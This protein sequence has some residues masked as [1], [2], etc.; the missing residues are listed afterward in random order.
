MEDWLSHFQHVQGNMV[1]VLSGLIEAETPTDDKQAI[2][3]LG[4]WMATWAQGLGAK[5]EIHEQQRVGNVTICYWNSHLHEKP[6]LILCHLDTV[7][8][9]G[10][11][12]KRPTHSEGDILYGVGSYDMK[13]GITVAQ[14]V[15]E[16][17]HKLN[18]FPQR[19]I[20]LFL[21]TDEEK[22]SHFSRELI[23]TMGK[24][25]GLALVME[26]ALYEDSIVTERKG[27]GI[28]Q[29]VA[30]GR[31]A[32]SGSD[33]EKGVNAI[34]EMAYQIGRITA[35]SDK[36]LGTTA[37]PTMIQGGINHNVIPDECDITINV[38]AKY[39]TEA[40]RVTRD[41]LALGKETHFEDALVYVTGGFFRPPMEHNATM[42]TTVETLQRLLDFPVTEVSKGGGSDGNFTAALGIPTLDGLGPTGGGAHSDTEFVN[43]SSMA[44][45][46]AL[47]STILCDWPYL[48][49]K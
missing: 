28:F 45:R 49:E 48:G 1:W 15:I 30:M 37:I 4:L 11:V 19:P 18:K 7:H 41:L 46:A 8:P 47:L 24:Q 25:A 16:E 26:P 20:I 13:A 5:V 10:S 32:H 31:S 21:N 6:I 43:I 44:K 3:D 39:Q 12:E 38:R 34:E 2:D 33:P 29:M 22:G 27:V 40:D 42:E 14:V 17:L 35:L 23:E 9:V 36:S